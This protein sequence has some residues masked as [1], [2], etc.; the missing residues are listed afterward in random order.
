MVKIF[1]PALGVYFSELCKLALPFCHNTVNKKN[2]EK[3]SQVRVS[4]LHII[5]FIA[6]LPIKKSTVFPQIRADFSAL[7]NIRTRFLHDLYSHIIPFSYEE[8]QIMSLH[9]ICRDIRRD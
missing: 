5:L 4:L 3:W 9:S 2:G 6:R 8:G 7:R 1:F